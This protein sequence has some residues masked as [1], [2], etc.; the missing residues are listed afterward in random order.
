MEMRLVVLLRASEKRGGSGALV[1]PA[2]AITPVLPSTKSQRDDLK[3]AR[4]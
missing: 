1:A 2:T 4:G 3:V